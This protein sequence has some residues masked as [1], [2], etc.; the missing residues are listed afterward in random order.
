VLQL[1]V[2]VPGQCQIAY[3]RVLDDDHL[4]I[5]FMNT[6]PNQHPPDV[7]E[8]PEVKTMVRVRK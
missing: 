7:F 5:H 6:I 8:G 3:V 2:I 4:L 1:N